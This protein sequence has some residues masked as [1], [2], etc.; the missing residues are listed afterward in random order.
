MVNGLYSIGSVEE[1]NLF[2][3]FMASFLVLGGVE[4]GD[5]IVFIKFVVLLG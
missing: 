2:Y 4:F 5:E 1:N 3:S